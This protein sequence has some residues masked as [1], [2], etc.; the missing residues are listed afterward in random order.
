VNRIKV[1]YRKL[2]K[3]KVWGFSDSS[4]FVELDATLKGKKALEILVHECLHLLYPADTEEEIVN[5]SITLTNTLWHE[6]YRKIDDK[7]DIPMQD[8]SL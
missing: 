5:K 4:G 6:K 3:H 7:E 2:G 8:G 1:K